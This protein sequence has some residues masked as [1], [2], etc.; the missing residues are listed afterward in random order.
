[1]GREKARKRGKNTPCSGQDVYG[2]PFFPNECTGLPDFQ[3][4]FQ[5]GLFGGEG[6]T[7]GG[8][9][10]GQDECQIRP[11]GKMGRK[12]EEEFESHELTSSVQVRELPRVMSRAPC[13]PVARPGHPG[14]CSGPR[15]QKFPSRAN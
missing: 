13:R 10:V 6:C 7:E 3:P 12:R 11:E 5:Q 2:N 15:R 9:G 14:P 4:K 8:E 1:M